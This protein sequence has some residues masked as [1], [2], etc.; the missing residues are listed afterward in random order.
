[1]AD[2][3]NVVSKDTILNALHNAMNGINYQCV[4]TYSFSHDQAQTI[5]DIISINNNNI[6]LLITTLIS[7]ITES[8]DS[9]DRCI[10]CKK[11]QKIS[12]KE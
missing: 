6:L 9:V 7:E 3:I 1:M 12:I 2:K 11:T 5:N 10:M 8:D 4:N